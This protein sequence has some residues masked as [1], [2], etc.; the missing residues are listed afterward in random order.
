MRQGRR[1]RHCART[2]PALPLPATEGVATGLGGQEPGMPID[3]STPTPAPGPGPL[4]PLSEPPHP[5]VPPV[6]PP[7]VDPGPIA[8]AGPRSRH[9]TAT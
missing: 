7:P 2:P 5:P 8:V 1:R 4:P 3:A 9:V 6:E